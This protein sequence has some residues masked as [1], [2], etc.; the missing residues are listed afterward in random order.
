MLLDCT[1]H[2]M[3]EPPTD[4]ATTLA[5]VVRPLSAIVLVAG[6]LV[7]ASLLTMYLDVIALFVLAGVFPTLLGYAGL[8]W[9]NAFPWQS[10]GT[11]AEEDEADLV[12]ELKQRYARGELDDA[13][14]ERKVETLL[15]ADDDGG[16]SATS[17]RE[18]E[19]EF[20][21]Y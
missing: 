6:L 14:M 1:V 16:I 8:A 19:S 21:R 7:S 18:R 5:D 17:G 13:E 2:A 15:N 4:R 11:A 9:T 3:T 12:E 10:T 20:G